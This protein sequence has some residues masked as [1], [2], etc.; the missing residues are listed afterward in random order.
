MLVEYA[1][2]V[3]IAIQ[4]VVFLFGGGAMVLRA[5]SDSKELREDMKSMQEELKGLAK[6]VTTQAVQAERL[7][8][9]SRRMTLLEERVEDLRRGKG[10]VN[11]RE[12]K[13]VDREY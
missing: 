6:V 7:N 4:T 5:S 10:Y 1:P 8:E 12:A 2:I 3:A 9:Q 11:D 13:V